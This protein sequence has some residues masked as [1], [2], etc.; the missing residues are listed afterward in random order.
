MAISESG[1]YAYLDSMC[2]ASQAKFTR[3]ISPISQM[4][5]IVEW[6][7]NLTDSP[8]KQMELVEDHFQ[9]SVEFSQYV[10]LSLLGVDLARSDSF[11]LNDDRFQDPSWEKGP[12][13]LLCRGFLLM[14]RWWQ[15]ASTG[16]PGMS[17]HHMSM[18]SFGIRQFFDI[19]SPANFIAT[20]P[21]L[22]K[23]TCQEKGQ[24]LL[25]GWDNFIEDWQRIRAQLPP[26]G[27][28]N[29]PVGEKVAVTPGKVVFRNRLIELI[30][31]LPAT[32]KV[33]GEPILIVP[34]WI[35]KYYILD[36]SPR[37][38]LVRF[39]VERGHTVFMISWKNPDAE[40]WALSME[41]Y[42]TLG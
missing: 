16:I 35:M 4:L 36:L 28:E 40:D 11:S 1:P 10:L 41:D 5:T 13:N 27:T 31:Y 7:A 25:R 23:I 38:S 39:L 20:N 37:N 3:N 29:F 26:V 19:Y 21:V 14:E 22:L 33:Y 30:Q 2:H 42:R 8:G 18:L 15:K 6:L 32:D 12:F 24:N 17:K 34:A 9:G